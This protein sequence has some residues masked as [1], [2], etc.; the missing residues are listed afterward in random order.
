MRRYFNG[1]RGSDC[2]LV[3]NFLDRLQV[4]MV[5]VVQTSRRPGEL[6]PNDLPGL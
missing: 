5:L 6:A 2:F 1:P 3:Q 4:P